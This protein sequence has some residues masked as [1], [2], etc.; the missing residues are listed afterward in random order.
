[1]NSQP[2]YTIT[3]SFIA[4][5][6]DGSVSIG[7]ALLLK[8]LIGSPFIPELASQTLFSITPGSIESQAVENFGPLAKYSTFIASALIWNPYKR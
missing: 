2:N 7:V 4:E 8:S 3:K 6:A 1:L 5:L